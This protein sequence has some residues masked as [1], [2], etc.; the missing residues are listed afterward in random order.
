[1]ISPNKDILT[2]ILKKLC[3]N[4]VHRYSAHEHVEQTNTHTLVNR[5]LPCRHHAQK[6]APKYVRM[7][8][9]YASM[10]TRFTSATAIACGGKEASHPS[11]H[12]LIG[13]LPSKL[14]VMRQDIGEVPLD[15]FLK[16]RGLAVKQFHRIIAH[17]L[18]LRAWQ[19][20]GDKAGSCVNMSS[21][22]QI[23]SKNYSTN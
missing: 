5:S 19:G 8:C 14:F 22:V 3:F 12:A 15:V 11:I 7:T 20:C 17:I 21:R 2:L 13:R 6:G 18:R 9:T 4:G 23:P 1:M 16:H 10:R